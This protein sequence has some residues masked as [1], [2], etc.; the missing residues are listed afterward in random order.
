MVDRGL[1]QG[2]PLSPFLFLIVA[3]GLNVML[4]NA[5]G[6]G[7]YEGYNV[8]TLKISHLQFADDTL[9]VGERSSVNI[10]SIKAVLQ[11]FESISGLKVIFHKSQL[12]GINVDEGWLNEAANFL[13]CCVG[14]VPFTYMGLSIRGDARRKSMWQSVLA[15]IRNRLASWNS[16]HL[17]LGG[18]IVLLKSVLNALPIY[19][20]SFFK[21]PI[22]VTGEI[23]SL[24]RRFLWSGSEGCRKIHWVAW[25]NI[26]K[27]KEES[28]LGLKHLKTF[29]HALLGKWLWRITTEGDRLWVRLLK[30]KYGVVGEE[31]KCSVRLQSRWWRD[32][33]NLEKEGCGY[34]P[35]WFSDGVKKSV[36]NENNTLFWIDKWVDGGPLRERFGR[37][38]SLSMDKNGM[39][40]DLI[41]G[42]NE[43]GVFKWR[44]RRELFQW[45][46]EPVGELENIISLAGFK[47]DG[48]DKWVW[49]KDSSG[50]YSVRSAYK[51][52]RV[53]DFSGEDIFYRKLWNGGA[54]LK[55][56][57]FVW[58]LSLDRIPTLQNLR[59]RNVKI[60]EEEMWF[61]NRGCAKVVR[62]RWKLLAICS[63]PARR[64]LRFGMSALSGGDFHLRCRGPVN[65]IFHNLE[66]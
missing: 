51:W 52:L 2:D 58:K 63:S 1:C 6:L 29:N 30:E 3:E 24:F 48:E 32:I 60:S 53:A 56:K 19:F 28:G 46:L 16:L 4:K 44:W 12:I 65:L 54:P 18:K 38:F 43:V 20:I 27:E 31:D 39:V 25:A 59:R 57:A 10:W 47:R 42:G 45:E 62:R 34:Q 41:R 14:H 7:S 11:L 50:V 36:G 13:N 21:L 17:S 55:V 66:V 49:G 22:G 9:L 64:I 33:Q 37:L 8:G 40:S 61:Y 35:K 5:D 26:C 23:E 15:K